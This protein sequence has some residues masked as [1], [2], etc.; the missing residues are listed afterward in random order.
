MG[1]EGRAT[2]LAV[3]PVLRVRSLEA[4]LL[5]LAVYVAWP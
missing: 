2:L 5:R 1:G 4:A 3:K